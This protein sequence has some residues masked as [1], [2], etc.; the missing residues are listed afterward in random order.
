MNLLRVANDQE[1]KIRERQR[2]RES[3]CDKKDQKV[4]NKKF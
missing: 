3:P 1:F 4:Q 2:E